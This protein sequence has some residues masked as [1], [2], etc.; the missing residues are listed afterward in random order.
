MTVTPDLIQIDDLDT[1]ATSVR[2]IGAGQDAVV[3]GP[4][5]STFLITATVAI[6][7]GHKIALQQIG[8]GDSV[9]KYG[10]PIGR[11][12]AAIPVGSHVHIHNVVSLSD[13]DGIEMNLNQ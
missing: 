1:V 4:T 6:R 13:E 10:R 5:G 3:A 2:D 11:A 12:T 8:E 9:L 7:A